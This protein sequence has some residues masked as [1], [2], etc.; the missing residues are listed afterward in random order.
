MRGPVH[1]LLVAAFLTISM[2]VATRADTFED[3][4]RKAFNLPQT[5]RIVWPP[6]A[7]MEA[8]SVIDPALRVI[9]RESKAAVVE[10]IDNPPVVV[11]APFDR[12]QPLDGLWLWRAFLGDRNRFGITLNLSSLES[13]DLSSTEAPPPGFVRTPDPNKIK[14]ELGVV[15]IQ[16]SWRATA[17]LEVLPGPTVSAAE[18]LA[19]R[20]LAIS[21]SSETVRANA[22]SI[23]LA[24]P[25]KPT[26]A[27]QSDANGSGLSAA[28]LATNTAR[29]PK[30]WALATI[31]SGR[32]QFLTDMQQDWNERSA[33]LAAEALSD[34]R[35]VVSRALSPPDQNGLSRQGVLDF[36]STFVR[37]ARQARAELMVVYYVGH[38]ER[39]GTGAL[40]LLMGDAPAE[41]MVSSTVTTHSVG[42][43]RDLAQ[44]V[45]QA[46]AEL[47]RR[48][49]TLD[50]AVM[51]RQL[52][53]AQLPFVLLVDG[54]LEDPTYQEARE[55]LGIVVDARGDEPVYVGPGDQ[56]TALNSQLA[57]LRNYPNDFP[58]LKSVAPIVLGATPGTAANQEPN[59]VW[60]LGGAVGPIARRLYDT[61]A[62][63]RWDP[64]RPSLIRIL[65]S[66]ADR[67]SIGPQELT[68]TV[69]WS[70]WLPYLHK[71][72]AASFKKG[73]SGDFVGNF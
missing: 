37:D 66:T 13:V 40:S 20:K 4:I 2:L 73:S 17:T 60:L 46:E 32:Y 58:Y 39:S 57:E 23:T 10:T 59:P 29:G 65:N 53:R 70:D 27:F 16:R 36:L 50:V 51:H 24:F 28:N 71:F 54:C 21:D 35:P 34:W 63:T 67:Q 31:A 11:A 41:R 43:L 5:A 22:K 64:D 55:R 68:G 44:I 3:D 48:P 30:R 62:R 6:R 19:L 56:G 8:G 33:N 1:R 25:G 42:N 26:L 52:E 18:W 61:V 7:A 45:D 69:S 49:G 72:D 14:R 15:T 9:A 47:A 38:M 12:L